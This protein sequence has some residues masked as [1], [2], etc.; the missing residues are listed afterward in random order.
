MPQFAPALHSGPHFPV[1][2]DRPSRPVRTS[3]KSPCR[4]STLWARQESS[5]SVAS[6][7]SP[8]SRCV[9]P[10][11]AGTSSRTPRPAIRS[12]ATVTSLAAAPAVRTC[13]GPRPLY[14]CA[15][16]KACESA[17]QCVE[18]CNGMAMTSS[19]NLAPDPPSS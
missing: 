3:T 6:M 2:A 17:S 9:R 4:T 19:A 13:S 12:A 7:A 11:S 14:I 5:R 16:W 8:I 1:Q 18:V 10:V 15:S